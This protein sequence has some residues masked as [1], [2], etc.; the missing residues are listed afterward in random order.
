MARVR[1]IDKAMP[2]LPQHIAQ[3]QRALDNS[4]DVPGAI[5]KIL[6]GVYTLGYRDGAAQAIYDGEKNGRAQPQAAAE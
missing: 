2:W 3:V 4:K 5:T 6:L 1:P